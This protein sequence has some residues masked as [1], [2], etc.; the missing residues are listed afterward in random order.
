M[1]SS[2]PTATAIAAAIRADGCQIVLEPAAIPMLADAVVGFA[3]DPDG[4][5]IELLQSPTKG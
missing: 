2:T 1:G 5:L 4:Y 3:K